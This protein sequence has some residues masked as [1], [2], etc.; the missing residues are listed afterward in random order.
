MGRQVTANMN[1]LAQQE[2]L[3]HVMDQMT[4]N[5]TNWEEDDDDDDH[6]DSSLDTAE[7]FFD[8]EEER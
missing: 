7:M 5:F 4:L 8:Q 3:A 6:D 1:R 2:A